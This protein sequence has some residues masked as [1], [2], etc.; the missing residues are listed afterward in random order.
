MVSFL[1]AF[2]ASARLD[3]ANVFR[4]LVPPLTTREIAVAILPARR[5]E[6]RITLQCAS[7]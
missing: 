1:L 2:V 7:L 4:L 6:N 5:K 3:F